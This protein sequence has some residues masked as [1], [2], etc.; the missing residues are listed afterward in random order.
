MLALHGLPSAFAAPLPSV[1]YFCMWYVHNIA[2]LSRPPL[3]SLPT[4]PSQPARPPAHVPLLP[5]QTLCKRPSSLSPDMT[6]CGATPLQL[7]MAEPQL[8]PEIIAN[9]R[10]AKARLVA[11]VSAVILFGGTVAYFAG[12]RIL[13][14]RPAHRRQTAAEKA[15][16]NQ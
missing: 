15:G 14:P 12:Q 11:G 8:T 4:L 16:S 9:V 3:V 10:R 2:P 13:N 1:Y 6:A 5:M 7:L